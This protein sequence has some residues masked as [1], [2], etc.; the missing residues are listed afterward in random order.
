MAGHRE[1]ALAPFL[2]LII[3]LWILLHRARFWF[4]L[5][6]FPPPKC[7]DGCVGK[8]QEGVTPLHLYSSNWPTSCTPLVTAGAPVTKG[9]GDRTQNPVSSWV[10]LWPLPHLWEELLETICLLGSEISPEDFS[11]LPLLFPAS[12]SLLSEFHLP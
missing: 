8:R 11:A 2:P 4:V 3:S 7:A 12:P 5:L 1:C 10:P 9:K 6:P